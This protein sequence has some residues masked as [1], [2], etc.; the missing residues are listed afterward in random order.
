MSDKKELLQQLSEELQTLGTETL[1][2]HD[3]LASSL[4]LHLTDHKCLGILAKVGPLS[5]GELA[6]YTGLTNG[7]VTFMIDR[8]EKK[9][10]VKRQRDTNDRR[11]VIIM[12][13][14]SPLNTLLK[15]H[16][17]RLDRAM[18]ATL[19]T[20]TEQEL[21]IILGFAH[22][23]RATLIHQRQTIHK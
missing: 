3:T 9:K 11:R 16:F 23:S 1:L 5:A 12:P 10:M 14:E 4:G 8:L 2:F 13:I 18:N 20:Y 17:S 15:Q 19:G 7:A 21:R 22:K 6:K